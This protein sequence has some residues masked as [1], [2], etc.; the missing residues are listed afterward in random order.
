MRQAGHRSERAFRELLQPTNPLLENAGQYVNIPDR[1]AAR[2]RT[3][4]PASP[5]VPAGP[6]ATPLVLTEAGSASLR[7]PLLH[8]PSLRFC[9]QNA[10]SR[11]L[12]RGRPAV[13]Q[14]PRPGRR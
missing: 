1:E 10:L 6:L 7:L 11:A 14:T 2:S 8:A 3:V 5:A 13:D 9:S 4:Q 12:K